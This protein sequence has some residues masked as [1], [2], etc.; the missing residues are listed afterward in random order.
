MVNIKL[1]KTLHGFSSRANYTDRRLSA[2]LVP[3]F[4]DRWCRVVS[5]TD[6]YGNGE[7]QSMK[8]INGSTSLLLALAAFSIS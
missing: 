3:T 2:K 4:E 7:Y 1:K 6:P 8:I 5:A